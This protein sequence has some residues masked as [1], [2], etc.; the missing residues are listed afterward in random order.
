M[1]GSIDAERLA[2]HAELE[3]RDPVEDKR[4]DVSQHGWSLPHEWQNVDGL[5]M[6]CHWCAGAE[7]SNMAL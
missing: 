1:H 7:R 2:K 4:G 3:R 6:F 5:R